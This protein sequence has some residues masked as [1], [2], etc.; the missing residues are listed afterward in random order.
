MGTNTKEQ[1]RSYHLE[2]STTAHAP[3]YLLRSFTSSSSVSRFVPTTNQILRRV[4]HDIASFLTGL[5][6]VSLVCIADPW[7]RG[8]E[9][10]NSDP[11]GSC[12][13]EVPRSR[14][15]NISTI[16]F[17]LGAVNYR[18]CVTGWFG[19]F[20]VARRTARTPKRKSSNILQI[21]LSDLPVRKLE[22]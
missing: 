13:L 20:G 4:L 6:R 15:Q 16:F 21:L 8:R 19:L 9:M 2:W 22:V 5:L 1:S 7:P 17:T 3:A 11:K 14:V 18:V 10:K 12:V